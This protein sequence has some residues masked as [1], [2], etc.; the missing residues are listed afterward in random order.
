VALFIA[1]YVRITPY[2][3]IALIR[4]GNTAAAIS[5]G[6]AIVGFALPL[7]R[8]VAQSVNLA[9]LGIWALVALVAQLA[10]FFVA[11][12]IFKDIARHIEDGTPAPAIFLASLSIAIGLLNAAAMTE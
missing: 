10:A 7:A 4:K 5:L 8:A 1:I 11:R 12:A 9:D 2:R 6:G 3:E